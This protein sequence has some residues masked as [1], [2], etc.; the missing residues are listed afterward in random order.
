[1][2]L[3]YSSFVIRLFGAVFMSEWHRSYYSFARF[4]F[5]DALRLCGVTGGDSVLMPSYICRDVLAPVRALGAKVEFYDVDRQLRPLLEHAG[6]PIDMSS[7]RAIMAVNY[8]GFPQ[9]LGDL[10]RLGQMVG[11]PI[12]EDNA[13]GYLSRDAH[14]VLLGRRTGIGFTSFRKTIRVVNGAYLD[15]DARIFP[16]ALQLTALPESRSAVP[17]GFR[18]RRRVSILEHSLGVS[19]MNPARRIAR[20]GRTMIGKP[21]IPITAESETRMPTDASVH[22]S[23]IDA[24][25]LVDV[26]REWSRRRETYSSVAA[27]LSDAGFDL[28]FEEL[29]KNT[30]PW[31]I[32]FFSAP[33]QIHLARRALRGLGL[34]IFRWPDLPLAVR[35]ECPPYYSQIFLVGMM[36]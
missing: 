6:Q 24:L 16:S 17:L 8:F 28:V 32:P 7:V 15:A 12:I 4:A 29:G 34:E 33:S 21:A 18:I 14:D 2:R 20:T 36:L 10:V 1:M 25:G 11:A 19:L 35:D 31:G 3:S 30:V 9:Q 22:R 26:D 23:A 13:H 5:L 27:R